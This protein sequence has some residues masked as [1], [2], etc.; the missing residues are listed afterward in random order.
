MKNACSK[1]FLDTLHVKKLN[2][3]KIRRN[4][5]IKWEK[6]KWEIEIEPEWKVENGILESVSDDE[7][8]FRLF[9]E[10]NRYGRIDGARCEQ[11]IEGKKK[12]D[13]L[14]YELGVEHQCVNLYNKNIELKFLKGDYCK[15]KWN[16]WERNFE[17][18]VKYQICYFCHKFMEYDEKM[19]NHFIGHGGG[20]VGNFLLKR[21]PICP[22]CF[23]LSDIK[24]F[25]NKIK[26]WIKYKSWVY[27]DKMA[28]T[29]LNRSFEIQRGPVEA[30]NGKTSPGVT[31]IFPYLTVKDIVDEAINDISDFMY[32]CQRINKK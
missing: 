31:F 3:L 32:F 13:L 22:E 11:C 4:K 23:E 14:F 6:I 19:E 16:F 10:Y 8:R 25:R 1:W 7:Y 12:C 17:D 27:I 5:M 2:D 20:E 18:P 24:A 29:I 9:N 30:Y 28:E 26:E 15:D 21:F